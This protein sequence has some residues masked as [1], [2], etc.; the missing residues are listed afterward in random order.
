MLYVRN[1]KCTRQN[2]KQYKHEHIKHVGTLYNLCNVCVLLKK[3][4]KT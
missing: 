4:N 1:K 2:H 3:I